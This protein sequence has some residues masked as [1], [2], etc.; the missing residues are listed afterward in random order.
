[1]PAP[2]RSELGP[3]VPGQAGSG[4]PAGPE[5]QEPESAGGEP[6]WRHVQGQTVGP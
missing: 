2:E 6:R 4:R 1:M 5:P 3:S